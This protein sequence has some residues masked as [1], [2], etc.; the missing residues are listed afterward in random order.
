MAMLL[1][2]SHFMLSDL[3]ASLAAVSLY[4]LFIL[5]PGYTLG[6][7]L[8]LFDFRRR[9]PAFRLAL[10]LPLSISVCPIAIYLVSRFASMT[11]VWAL[12]AALWI[13]FAII[14]T[15][16]GTSILSALP[17]PAKILALCWLLLVL[18]SS[19]DLEFA[20]RAYYP[21]TAFDYSIRAGF[22]HSI[23]TGGVPP[24][25]PFFFPGH[26][27]ALRYHYFWLLF[28]SLVDQLGGTFVSPRHAWIGG[29]FWCGLAFMAL[30]ALYFRL[31]WYRGQASFPRRTLLAILLLGVT[32]LD[33]LPTAF[34]WIL[35]ATGMPA[36]VFPSLEWWNEQVDGFV[37][38]GLWVAHH[39]AALIACFTAFLILGDAAAQPRARRVA[40]ILVAAAALAS[41]AGSSIY[42]SLVFALFLAVWVAITLWR[43]WFAETAVLAMTGAA[44]LLLLLPYVLA[45]FGPGAGGPPLQFWVR[46]FHPANAFIT[47]AHLSTAWRFSLNGLLLPLNYFLELGFFF[48]AG[49]LWWRKYRLKGRPLSRS[50]LA[51]AAMVAT[52]VVVCTFVR[53]SV[54][55]NND[56]GWRGFLIAQFGLLLWSVDV[57]TAPA[58][59]FARERRTLTILLI[60]GASGTVYDVLILRFYPMLADAGIVAE[61]PWMAP[62]L[63]CGSRNYAG[64][65]AYQWAASS[66]PLQ[67]V[68]QFDPHVR[69]Q[70]TSALLY[71]DR[72]IAA[73]DSHCLTVFGGDPDSCAVMLA[74]LN[75]VYPAAG[76][77]APT[78]LADVCSGLPI[79]LI[80]AKDTD[81]VWHNPRSW[82]WNDRPVFANRFYRLFPCHPEPS[83]AA[84]IALR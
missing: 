39:L 50:A 45:L 33:I 21:V 53:S 34:L 72:Q 60:L 51:I 26:S 64:R 55:G 71:S 40:Y 17:R 76:Q 61:T 11:S 73:A 66:I 35:H 49:S 43:K 75:Q 19:I 47:A 82:V 56:L 54:I 67:A 37:W 41:A 12:F 74:K 28:A 78:T 27:V 58:A 1:L 30:I 23:S 81:A 70:D 68:V 8:N 3:L 48:I 25:N 36:A 29:T 20:R 32:G 10:S 38:T 69:I 59:L 52:S 42:V 44:A 9:T 46:P 15:R 83:P 5:I 4:P 16:P 62:D 6:F 84:A 80:V 65:E 57:L 7:C 77:T 18:F 63:Q 79:Q 13:A 14:V 22:I 31:F 2:V 24:A